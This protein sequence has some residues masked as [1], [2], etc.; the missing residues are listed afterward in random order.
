MMTNDFSSDC[1]HI[2]RMLTAATST[3][4]MF[5]PPKCGAL[6]F[7]GIMYINAC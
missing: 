3:V 4:S 5:P 6:I 1:K 7:Y 2:D